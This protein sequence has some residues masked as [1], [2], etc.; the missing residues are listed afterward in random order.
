MEADMTHAYFYDVPS[1]PE[2]YRIITTEIGTD[3][4]A[5]LISQ[6]V[7]RHEQGLRH[8][9]VWASREDWERFREDRVRPA[10]ARVL[11]RHGSPEPPLPVEH[12]L[13]VVDIQTR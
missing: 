3:H 10:V 13:D 1:T 2:M 9:G 12:E 11:A 4:P 8:Y 7:V 5:G 6:L